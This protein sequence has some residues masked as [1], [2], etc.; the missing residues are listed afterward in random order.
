[1]QK[2][3]QKSQQNKQRQNIC[4]ILKQHF[5]FARRNDRLV[6]DLHIFKK[7]IKKIYFT[8]TNLRPEQEGRDQWPEPAAAC[9]S[10]I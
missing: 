10:E 1:M 2:I 6:G 8:S 9:S 4:N 3:S 5:S 7:I